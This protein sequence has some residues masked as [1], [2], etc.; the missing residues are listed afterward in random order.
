[1]ESLEPVWL[2]HIG[3]FNN[4]KPTHALYFL[5]Q[6]G[7]IPNISEVFETKNKILS[8]PCLPHT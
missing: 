5:L 3:S 6:F 8:T 4:D 1:M 7:N 2:L